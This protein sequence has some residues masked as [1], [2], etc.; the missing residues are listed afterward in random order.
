MLEEDDQENWSGWMSQA[1]KW[2]LESD[3]SGIEKVLGAYGGMGSFND[4]YLSKVT[5]QNENF[6]KLR[7]RA[8]ELATEI[9]HESNT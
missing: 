7:T 9:M 6:S 5:R 1:R 3:H 2:I 4:T 8:W